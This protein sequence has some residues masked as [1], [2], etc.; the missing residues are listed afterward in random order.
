MVNTDT[1]SIAWHYLWDIK[2]TSWEKEIK[3][4]LVFV[5]CLK[6]ADLRAW[7]LREGWAVS[8]LLIN[9]THS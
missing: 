3:K 6:V 7:R 9:W 5:I 8:L 2:Q 1:E 4:W